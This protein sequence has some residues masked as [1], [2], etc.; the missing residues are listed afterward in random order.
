MATSQSDGH[1]KTGSRSGFSFPF[2]LEGLPSLSRYDAVLVA[3][4]LLFAVALLGHALLSVSLHLSVAAGATV[5]AVVLVDVL[6]LR[7][8]A[9]GP[10]D[11]SP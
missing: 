4:P 9:D 3:I 11:I 5:S 6:Y 8:P 7:P 1:S 10:G 2:S